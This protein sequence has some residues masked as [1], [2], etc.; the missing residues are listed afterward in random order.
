MRS[1]F[2]IFFEYPSGN[3]FRQHQIF[4]KLRIK[5]KKRLLE[6]LFLHQFSNHIKNKKI[7]VAKKKNHLRS[8][9]D[10]QLLYLLISSCNARHTKRDIL[11]FVINL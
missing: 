7:L 9:K 6:H 3:K 4:G 11:L 2:D 1:E 8:I 5:N 10:L